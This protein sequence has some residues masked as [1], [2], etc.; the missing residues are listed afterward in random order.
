MAPD[1][2]S[3]ISS[4]VAALTRIVQAPTPPLGYGSDLSCADDLDPL[5]VE[6]SSSTLILGQA[7]YRRITT[8]RG[9]LADDA[10]YGV[11]VRGYLS[12]G[13][14]TAQISEAQGVIASEM[15]KDERVSSVDVVISFDGTTFSVSAAVEPVDEGESFTL[16]IA[17]TDGVAL[18]KAVST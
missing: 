6:L 2:Q 5:F 11:D 8:Q 18:L 9:T 10:D 4:G 12:R 7:L 15:R 1:M 13:M 17:V 16:V 3:A 14:T